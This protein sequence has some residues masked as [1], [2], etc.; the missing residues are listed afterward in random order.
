MAC[1]SFRF[2]SLVVRVSVCNDT[3]LG[4]LTPP[5]VC[6]PPSCGYFTVCN[7]RYITMAQVKWD[8]RRNPGE[9]KE[10]L[11]QLERFN[12]DPQVVVIESP[13]EPG[14]AMTAVLREF[15]EKA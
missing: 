15:E 12:L 6:I 4:F 13:D 9:L 10:M 5:P 1:P 2:G 3:T 14:S 8:P 11:M 7:P